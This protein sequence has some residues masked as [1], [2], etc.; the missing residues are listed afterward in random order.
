MSR[1]IFRIDD[2]PSYR[3]SYKLVLQQERMHQH[4]VPR[5]EEID[6]IRD[7]LECLNWDTYTLGFLHF[8]DTIAGFGILLKKG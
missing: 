8:D 1:N 7:A 5:Y 2:L 6:G 3:R 4:N